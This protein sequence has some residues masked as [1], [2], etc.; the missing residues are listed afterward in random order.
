MR[1]LGRAPRGTFPA[2]LCFI[3]MMNLLTALSFVVT[4]LVGAT[5]GAWLN[6]L[7][8]GFSGVRAKPRHQ[9]VTAIASG[10]TAPVAFD[11]DDVQREL[12]E[13]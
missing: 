1:R 4:F 7:T 3:P 5:A 11:A 8:N 10:S 6:S 12:A 13:R 9:A 2:P